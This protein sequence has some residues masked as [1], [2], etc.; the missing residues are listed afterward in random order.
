M[1]KRILFATSGTL[2]AYRLFEERRDNS[3]THNFIYYI[4]CKPRAKYAILTGGK[5]P[6]GW[7]LDGSDFNKIYKGSHIKYVDKSNKSHYNNMTYIIGLNINV[8]PMIAKG[9]CRAGGM[10]FTGLKHER[11]WAGRGDIVYKVTIPDDA[12]VYTE[13]RKFKADKFILSDPQPNPH[14]IY[15]WRTGRRKWYKV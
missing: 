6:N 8:E 9:Y 7:L 5:V 15:G 11:T 3:P 14:I 12:Y 10:Y 2:V 4:M 13:S 1:R